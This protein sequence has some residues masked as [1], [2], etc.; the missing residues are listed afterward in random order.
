MMQHHRQGFTLIELMIVVVIIAIFAAIA[1]PSYQEYVRRS[2]LA[3]AQ[4]EM[5]KIATLLEKHRSRN[6]TYAG[7]NLKDV[8]GFYDEST[9]KFN[10]PLGSTDKK[11]KYEI[12]LLDGTASQPL[13]KI[14]EKDKNT[15]GNSWTMVANSQD[16]LNYSLC[17]TSY[18]VRYKKKASSI[19]NCDQ[20]T[21]TW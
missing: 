12:T 10:L 20:G 13:N 14:N 5:Q 16:P 7:F 19:T 1:I 6:F 2:N 11:I 4:Q 18:G 9:G 8:N 21:E 3:A 15:S 17:M